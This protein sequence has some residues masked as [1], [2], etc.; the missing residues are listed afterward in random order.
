MDPTIFLGVRGLSHG[1]GDVDCEF[2]IPESQNLTSGKWT[3]R[4]SIFV[5]VFLFK[6]LLNGKR[7]GKMSTRNAYHVFESKLLVDNYQCNKVQTQVYVKPH[8]EFH[9]ILLSAP[10][11]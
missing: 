5:C 1:E 3:T 7:T 4:F 2:Q 11:L 10:Y 8:R 9:I 6:M